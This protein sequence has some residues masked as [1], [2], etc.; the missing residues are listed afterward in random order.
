MPTLQILSQE[1]RI[2]KLAANLRNTVD[3]ADLNLQHIYSGHLVL[4]T[5]GHVENS[6][7]YILSEYGR[8]HGNKVLSNFVNKIVA[9]N[10]SLNCRKIEQ[11]TNQFDI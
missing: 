5:A 8:K 4:A 7:I 1:N 3:H 11:I 6:V 9:R 2:D 10:N